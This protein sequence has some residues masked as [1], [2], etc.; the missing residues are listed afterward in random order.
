MSNAFRKLLTQIHNCKECS[1]ALP[2]PPK[3]VFRLG[4]VKASIL[5][6]GQAPGMKAHLSATPWNDPSGDRLRDWMGVTKEQF[7][8][9]TKVAIMPMGFCYPGTGKSGDLPPRPECAPLWH[10]QV[11]KHLPNIKLTLLIGRYAQEY[12]LGNRRKET[13]GDT[14]KNWREYLKDGYLPLV[15]PSP[16]NQI[17]LKKNPWFEKE[18]VPNFRKSVARLTRE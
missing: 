1:A 3:P 11:L 4:S 8:D 14:V 5:I 15:H 13:L 7:S 9:I 10:D 18:I 12:Y 2:C 17:W 6:I 16:R